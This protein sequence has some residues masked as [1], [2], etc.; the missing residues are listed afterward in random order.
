MSLG[1]QHSPAPTSVAHLGELFNLC[2][3]HV[4]YLWV[5]IWKEVHVKKYKQIHCQRVVNRRGLILHAHRLILHVGR[6]KFWPGLR[7][8][9]SFAVYT[10]LWELGQTTSFSV[11]VYVFS[12]ILSVHGN[13]SCL[14]R[15]LLKP[16]FPTA[17]GREK[18]KPVLF[19]IIILS[20][21]RL[22]TSFSWLDSLFHPLSSLS[23]R[24]H[25][26]ANFLAW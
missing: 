12:T 19:R 7:A 11:F 9:G 10:V 17:T 18:I 16:T 3:P 13:V 2:E 6:S 14:P 26:T 20:F 8:L 21:F 22:W 1:E 24:P 23:T 5:G 4:T 25:W 15:V